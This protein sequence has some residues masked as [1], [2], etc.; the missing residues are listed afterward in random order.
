MLGTR[1]FC[2]RGAVCLL[3]SDAG[4]LL[5]HPCGTAPAISP[6]LKSDSCLQGWERGKV[7]F[8][9]FSPRLLT[10]SALTPIFQSTFFFT[11]TKDANS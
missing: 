6:V 4:T 5:G 10:C 7:A 3:E 2:A 9:N 11:L 1:L 8:I